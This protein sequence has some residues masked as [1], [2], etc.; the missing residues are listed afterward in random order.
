MIVLAFA[1][2]RY[3]PKAPLFNR[4]VLEPP[5]PEER[6]TLSHREALADY[7]HLVGRTG[8]AVTDLRPAGKA[9]VDD[10]LIDVIALGEPLDRGRRGYGRV[11][12]RQARGGSAN[13]V[14]AA[15]VVS[16]GMHGPA[17]SR[18]HRV[19]SARGVRMAGLAAGFASP[20]RAAPAFCRGAARTAKMLPARRSHG[21]LEKETSTMNL[22]DPLGWAVVLLV[23]GCGL[24]V[25][26][27]FIPSGG[28]FGFLASLAVIGS[29]VM[30]LPPRR[31]H[32]PQLHGD[33]RVRRADRRR[34][35]VQVLA[36]DA[37]GQGVSGRAARAKPEVKPDDPRRSLVG[38][39]G[40]AQSKMLPSG[41]VLI[42][43]QLI[44]AVSQGLAIDPGE[45]VIVVEVRAN[46]VMVRPARAHEVRTADLRPDDVLSRPT[47]D[48]GLEGIDEPL[49]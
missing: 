10:N 39:V 20:L 15:A 34:P 24:L 49:S 26:E 32:G 21:S 47:E 38:R 4:M 46:R 1:T 18:P 16:S 7:S 45:P 43:G 35:G 19:A 30:A 41:S 33:R 11:G 27:V 9:L 2:R 22:L 8:E 42:D 5:P 17:C 25:L 37:D 12:A 44:D 36:E 48:F 23:L 13:H 14:T 40:V 6:V 31:D 3:L 29:L 28:I